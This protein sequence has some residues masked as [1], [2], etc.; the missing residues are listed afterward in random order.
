ME[1]TGRCFDMGTEVEEDERKPWRPKY[2][3][4]GP[5]NGKRSQ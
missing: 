1:K 5:V 4:E 3:K 2:R